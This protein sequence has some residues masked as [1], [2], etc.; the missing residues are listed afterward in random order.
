MAFDAPL[1]A[2]L[3]S[4]Q[5]ARLAAGSTLSTVDEGEIVA[6]RG[7]PAT[8]LIVVETGALTAIR[9]TADGQ[10]LRLGDFP[11][12][13]AI[14]KAAVLD[15][16]AHTATWMAAVRSQIRLIPA[17]ELFAIIDDVPA[18]RRH[19]LRI[20]AGQVRDHQDDLAQAS[21]GDAITRTAAWLA[22]AAGRA[23]PKITLPGGQQGLAENIGMTRVSVNRALRSLT[24]EGLVRVEPGAVTV[25][26]PELLALRANGSAEEQRRLT[27]V[28]RVVD[29]DPAQDPH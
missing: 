24:G 4:D 23:G 12:P 28:P 16:G 14:D 9:E 20:L 11:A 8:R 2:A 13:C 3:G 15:S 10:R 1:F 26:A 18:V 17:A 29:P 7:T 6:H 19:V 27:P 21:F 22:R 5:L 25:L